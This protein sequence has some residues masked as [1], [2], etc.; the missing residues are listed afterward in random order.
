ML[1]PQRLKKRSTSG[2]FCLFAVS[3][4]LLLVLNFASTP[5]SEASSGSKYQENPLKQLDVFVLGDSQILFNGGEA[6]LNFFLE[7]NTLCAPSDRKVF[8]ATANLE[9][10]TSA[11]VGVLGVRGAGINS[12]VSQE[13]P[14]KDKICIPQKTWPVNARGFGR[15]RTE[16]KKFLQIGKHVHYPL[17]E[18]GQSPLEALF[19]TVEIKPKLFVIAMTG[20][21]ARFWSKKPELADSDARRLAAQIPV[22]VPC[23]YM[24]TAPTYRKRENDWRTHG[25]N[26]FFNALKKHGTTCGLVSGYQPKTIAAFQGNKTYFKT[27]EDGKVEDAFHSNPTGQE[28]FLGLV[29]E[30]VCGVIGGIY[31]VGVN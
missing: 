5:K 31:G 19:K 20:K 26:H 27:G 25:Q 13:G 23:I 24:T 9:R 12:W 15:L 3:F 17:C 22:D 7:L 4:L 1:K 2:G 30:D 6:Y 21:R 28:A 18:A 10:L 8:Q 11:N 16:K 14:E 29:A